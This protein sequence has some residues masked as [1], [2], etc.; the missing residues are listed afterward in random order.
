MRAARVG[1]TDGE[2]AARVAADGV[3]PDG[4]PADGYISDAHAAEAHY[5]YRD[6]AERERARSY[7]A[8]A[9]GKSERECAER[10]QPERYQADAEESDAYKAYR[11][12]ARCDVAYRY[13]ALGA[14]VPEPEVDMHE[15]QAADA[16]IR[17][18]FQAH[19]AFIEDAAAF[20]LRRTIAFR[21]RVE[22]QFVGGQRKQPAQLDEL[23]RFGVC[24]I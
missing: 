18:V 20:A 7:A 23:I 3:L 1:L 17:Y 12:D 5:A 16:R 24:D 6:A 8:R 2:K 14:V 10:D 22:K 11:D 9:D 21:A 13:Y 15:R 4:K 19:S